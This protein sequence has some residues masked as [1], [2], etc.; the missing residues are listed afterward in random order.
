MIH[1]HFGK[2]QFTLYCVLVGELGEDG[3]D[4]AAG[5]TPVGVEIDNDVGG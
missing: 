1:I 4:S 2:R 3:R 5:G